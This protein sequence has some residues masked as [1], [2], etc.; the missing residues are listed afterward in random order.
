MS[1]P[2]QRTICRHHAARFHVDAQQHRRHAVR[3]CVEALRDAAAGSIPRT[4]SPARSMC[5]VHTAHPRNCRQYYPFF[6]P[7]NALSVLPT[8]D[9]QSRVRQTRL[10]SSTDTVWMPERAP[11]RT[12]RPA[13]LPVFKQTTPSILW[14]MGSAQRRLRRCTCCPVNLQDMAAADTPAWLIPHNTDRRHARRRLVTPLARR[15]RRRAC[16]LQ[17]ALATTRQPTLL[18]ETRPCRLRPRARF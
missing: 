7:S 10:R 1:A 9:A 3:F 11:W 14:N 4:R 18:H 2:P 16:L 8:R 17:S 12:T 6:L 15:F 5:C 13:A